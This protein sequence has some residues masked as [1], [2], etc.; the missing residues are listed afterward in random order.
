MGKFTEFKLPLKSL[1][2]G[3]HSFEYHLGKKFFE[4]MESPDIHDA[5]L[6]VALTV[7]YKRDL[8]TLNFKI[9]GT[10]TLICDRCLDDLIMPVDT[11]YNINVKYG[12][13]YN[14]EADDLLV[15]PYGDNYLNVAYMLYDTVALTIP[16]KHVHPMGKCNRQM[17]QMLRKHR[18]QPA[19][20][21]AEL[22]ETLID[23]MDSMDSEPDNQSTDPRWD[24]LKGLGSEKTDTE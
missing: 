24:A 19:D 20:E 13:D 6:H 22:E 12:D 21:D 18:T 11:D 1:P 14:D 15:I 8:Y 10:I 2:E 17:S 4:N 7:T 5:D 16:M 9:T 3:V 23:E